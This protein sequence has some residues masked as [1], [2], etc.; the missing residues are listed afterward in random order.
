LTPF[1]TPRVPMTGEVQNAIVAL[2][3]N[4][5]PMRESLATSL[6][7]ALP[8]Y[9]V[10]LL[11][12]GSMPIQD[13]LLTL[14][15]GCIVIDLDLLDESPLELCAMLRSNPDTAYTPVLVAGED[16]GADQEQLLIRMGVQ[17]VVPKPIDAARLAID[18]QRAL[19]SSI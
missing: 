13:A 18:I 16:I 17:G 2:V 15:P 9:E 4:G 1:S 19:L 5:G 8:G 10:A 11:P 6:R 14:L 12:T 3:L 7:V